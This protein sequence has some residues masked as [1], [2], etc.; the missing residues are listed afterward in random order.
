MVSGTLA[1]LMYSVIYVNV[2]QG[3]SPG[4]GE[5]PV[6]WRAIPSIRVPVC[7]PIPPPGLSQAQGG[8]SL[9]LGGPSQAQ[10]GPIQALG[11]QARPWGTRPW[12]A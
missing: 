6:E 12:K 5:S 2:K 8:P 9:A 1:L 7:P 11:V 10:E 4:R 3:I